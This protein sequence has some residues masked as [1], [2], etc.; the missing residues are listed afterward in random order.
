MLIIKPLIMSTQKESTHDTLDVP[1]YSCDGCGIHFTHES[2]LVNHS[3]YRCK[4]QY[5]HSSHT[6]EETS[7]II[8]LDEIQQ[9]LMSASKEYMGHIFNDYDDTQETPI[10]R[11]ITQ[12]STYIYS[13]FY[14]TQ[15]DLSRKRDK[16]SNTSKFDIQQVISTDLSIMIKDHYEIC[17]RYNAKNLYG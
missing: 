17:F 5:N 3:R 10:Y 9:K 16:V 7:K 11:L 13:N 4:T 15:K 12:M 8:Q 6:D 14:D 2:D 1:I